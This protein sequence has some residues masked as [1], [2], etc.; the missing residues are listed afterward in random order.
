[1]WVLFV[2]NAIYMLSN[3]TPRRNT[4]DRGENI[5]CKFLVK[6]GFVIVERNHWRKWGEIDIVAKNLKD[7]II[8][9]IEV[10]SGIRDFSRE[11]A[12]DDSYSPADNITYEKKK[13]FVRIIQTY[14]L[15]NKL[16]ECDW[17][18]DVILAYLDSGSDK[19]EI[20]VLEDI[21]L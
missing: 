2:Y 18:A 4:G 16:E 14:V 19:Y 6:Q 20:E 10:K 5:V 1:M 12:L 3:K 9:F 11:V 17:Q 7:S 21:D 15:E 13:R 8:H